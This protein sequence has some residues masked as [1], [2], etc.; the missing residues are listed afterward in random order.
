[1]PV[2]EVS[3][4]SAA[5]E[6]GQEESLRPNEVGSVLHCDGVERIVGCYWWDQN[7]GEKSHGEDRRQGGVIADDV[8][9]VDGSG[10]WLHVRAQGR[11]GSVGAHPLMDF[12]TGVG[13]SPAQLLAEGEVVIMLK[14]GEK[15]KVLEFRPSAILPNASVASAMPSTTPAQAH[16]AMGSGQRRPP[17]PHR[18]REP[19][20][21]SLRPRKPMAS[22]QSARSRFASR[23]NR[24][25]CTLGRQDSR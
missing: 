9:Q 7:K 24:Y 25:R 1:M 20:T 2:H 10:G 21:C 5:Q 17:S 12:E 11:G 19:S 22:R 16:S 3:V 15:R 8:D 6:R 4:E 18:S 13:L 23:R 14:R